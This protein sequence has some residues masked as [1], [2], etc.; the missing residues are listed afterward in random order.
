[1]RVVVPADR[2]PPPRRSRTGSAP[3]GTV[4]CKPPHPAGQGAILPHLQ[5]HRER[6]WTGTGTTQNGWCASGVS[7]R[8]STASAGR[9]SPPCLPRAPPRVEEYETANGPADYAVGL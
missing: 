4:R 3:I 7:I 9:A 6:L 5:S 2:V 1:M 8:F